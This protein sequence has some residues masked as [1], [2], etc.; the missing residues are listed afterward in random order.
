[1][2]QG[3]SQFTGLAGEYYVSYCLVV[4]GYHASL[5][6]GNAPKCRYFGCGH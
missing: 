6:I 5:T 4:R 1:M 3:A 2:L